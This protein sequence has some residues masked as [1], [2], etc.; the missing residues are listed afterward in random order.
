MTS[1]TYDAVI[2]DI[3]GV[4]LDWDPRHLYRRLIPDPD[5]ME[6]FLAEVCS[7]A[8]NAEQDRG[9]AFSEAIKEAAAR[10]PE[11]RELIEAYWKRWPE[12]LD[13]LIP[14][15]SEVIAEAA[16]AGTA[17]FAI[18][19]FSAETFPLAVAG[20]E[21]LSG[22][23]DVVVSGEVKMIKPDP[24]IFHYALDRFGLSPHQALFVDDK[25][26]NVEAAEKLGMGTVLFT[27]AADLRERM[28]RSGLL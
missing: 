22:F 27:D 4:I 10:H 17:L 28:K 6:W 15:T 5:E 3:G 24:A 7:D 23:R 25:P 8:W 19:N 9:R 12:T 13:G 2:F 21:V 26:A 11:Y 14:G 18:T 16:A 20:Y 1:G